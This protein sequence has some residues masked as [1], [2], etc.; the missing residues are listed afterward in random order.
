MIILVGPPGEGKTEFVNN[1]LLPLIISYNQDI[2]KTK[3]KCIKLTKEALEKEKSVVIDSTIQMW[4][5]A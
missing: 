2:C 1:Y 3:A 4:F 5:L